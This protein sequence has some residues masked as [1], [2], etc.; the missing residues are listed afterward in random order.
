[1]DTTAKINALQQANAAWMTLPQ[2]KWSLMQYISELTA[3]IAYATVNRASMLS[4]RLASAHNGLASSNSQLR[5][6]S[7]KQCC[8]LLQFVFDD[9]AFR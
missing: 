2:K 7:F 6:R 5:H 3:T 1:M 9:P 8:K 4:L